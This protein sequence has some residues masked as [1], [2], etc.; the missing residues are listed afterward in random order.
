MAVAE[1][2]RRTVL[3]ALV[4][5]VVMGAWTMAS[6]SARADSSQ[7]LDLRVLLI[8]QS[9]GDPTTQAWQSQLTAEGVAYTTVLA[10]GSPGSET[11]ALPTLV[12][13]T[14]PGHGLF[15]GVVVVPSVYDFPWGTLGPVWQYESE[16]GVRQ[17]DGYV[18]PNGTLNGIDPAT[19]G[20]L[21]GTTP[22]LTA[23]GLAAFPALSGPVPLDT[24]TYGYPSTVDPPSGDTVTSLLDDTAGNTL[25]AVDQHADPDYVTGQSG[26]SELSITFDY[27]SD[28]T[29]WLLLAPSLI[30]WL[31]DGAHLGLYRNYVEM[32]IDDTFTPDN[33]WSTV[34]HSND[35][36]DSGS[37]RMSAADVVYAAQWSRANSFRLDQL[38]NGGGSV[39]YQ[40][41][42]LGLGA[43]GPD[44]VLAQFQATDPT[45]GTPYADDFG[46]ISH[47]YD[48]PYLDVGCATQNYIEAELN[49]NTNWAAAAPGSTPGTGGL[50]ITDSTDTSDA[51]GAEDSQVFVP[52]NHSGLADLVPGT[53]ATVDPPDLDAENVS[54]TGGTLAAGTYDYAV[55]DQFNSSDP[56]SVDQSQAY[57]TNP[58]TVPAGGSVSLVWQA[59]CHAAD[60]LIYRE[61]AGSGNWSLVG[62][63]ATPT[64]AT[65]PD[66]SSGDPQSTTDVTG[67][68]EKE[69]TFTD[70]GTTG[71]AE[72]SGWTPPTAENAN[73]SPWEQN[74]YFVPAL[75]A[76]GITTVGADASKPYPDPPDTQFGIGTNYTGGEYPA[77]TSFGDGTATV[78]PRHP[79]NIFY[80]ASTEA[81]EV[82]EYNQLY[83]PES[84]GGTCVDTST[85][86]CLSAPATFADIVHSVVSGMFENML[87]NNP[88][89]TYVHQTNIMGQAPAGPATSGT[90]PTTPDTTGDGLLYSVLDPLLSEY[91][92]YFTSST[93]YQQPTLGQI[94]GIMHDQTAWSAALSS[95]S[96]VA[97]EQNGVIT[98]TNKGTTSVE[99]PVTAPL[100]SSLGGRTVGQAYGGTSSGWE[101]LAAGASLTL[102]TEGTAPAFTSSGAASTQVGSSLDVTVAT[103]GTPTAA[104]TES[105]ALPNGV[106]FVDNGDGTATLAG[107]PATG[108]G[109]T[110]PLTLTADNQVGSGVTQTFTLTVDQVPAFTSSSSASLTF[111]RPGSFTV[112]TS[113][114]P[115]AA[116]T[117]SGAL[118]NGVTFVDDGDGT[119]TLAGTPAAGS[120]GTYPLTLTADNQVGSGVTQAFTLTVGKVLPAVTWTTPAP[121]TYG[122]AL[123]SSQLDATASVAGRF[124]YTPAVG[125]VPTAG[126]DQLSVTFTPT[127]SADYSPVTSTTE[128]VVNRAVPVVTWGKIKSIAYGTPLGATQLDAHSATPGTFAYTPASGAVPNAGLQTLHAVFT[129][130]DAADYTTATVSDSILVKGTATKTSLS[131]TSPVTVADQGAAEFTVTVTPTSGAGAV[132]GTVEVVSQSVVLCTVTLGA[133]G[134]GTCTLSA[135]QLTAGHYGVKAE[136]SGNA[137]L[138]ASKSPGA[139]KLTVTG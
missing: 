98:V 121:I 135:G 87:S 129:P 86:T 40:N 101:N 104:L 15:D 78:V 118:P 131:F 115:T 67:G 130:T 12:D 50:G 119:A 76:V 51:L 89:P 61:V 26:V 9:G 14:D 59:I 32:N 99:V 16:F 22:T 127:D 85:T 24:G 10:Q 60:Y 106:T 28:Y 18:Y 54:A 124:T 63:Y 34:T 5:V 33:A 48:T 17:I 94:G 79:V 70:A 73:E 82:D 105:G 56:A 53:P 41:G 114:Y 83:L 72:P 64:S 38:F 136:F 4:G 96:T 88:E 31:T 37:L 90:P 133:G 92:S 30:D 36:S 81:Q 128:L 57:V 68:G 126:T 132:A 58:V 62:N 42:D 69:L 52:G 74:P 29:S 134:E 3:V 109:G 43:A 138:K 39:E 49:E 21:S 125:T 139:P 84:L 20:N 27:A 122:T 110:Y 117:E 116:L 6:P 77:G 80:N 13:P 55:T 35:Y 1:R 19:S 111:G 46:W 102:D 95:G 65:L 44:P 2:I 91:H 47:T 93:P 113:G 108:S 23:A 107:T 75:Q 97:T 66:N 100:G 8:G 120:G 103:S 7:S 123:S 71:T 137:D 25:I 45:T 11:L 112:T